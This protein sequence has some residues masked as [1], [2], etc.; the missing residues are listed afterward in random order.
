MRIDGVQVEVRWAERQYTLNSH[1][2]NKIANGATRNIL[3][4][5][6]ERNGLTETRIREDMEHICN[7]VIVDITFRDGHAYMSSN[8]VHNALFARTCMMSR[9]SYKG[10]KIEFYPDECD[11][12]LP[13]RTQSIPVATKEPRKQSVTQ[14]NRFDLLNIDDNHS[15]TDEEDRDYRDSQIGESND[16]ADTIDTKPRHGVRIGGFNAHGRE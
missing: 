14:L 6:A 2:N 3:I 1:V 7:F 16:S 13:V 12:P 4:R 9:R 11:V 15:S 10:C 8:S 5:F